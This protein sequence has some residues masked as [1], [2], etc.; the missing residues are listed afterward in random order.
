M[1]GGGKEGRKE[2]RMFDSLQLYFLPL[3]RDREKGEVTAL[4]SLLSTLFRRDPFCVVFLLRLDSSL[5]SFDTF[6]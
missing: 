3:A 5:R 4:T 1:R 6:I 2:S